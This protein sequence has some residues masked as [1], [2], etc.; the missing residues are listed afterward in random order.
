MIKNVIKFALGRIPY[1]QGFEQTYHCQ[2]CYKTLVLEGNLY[3]D[4]AGSEYCEECVVKHPS[5]FRLVEGVSVH[6]P[7][8][9]ETIH[10]SC[11]S[12]S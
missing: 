11:Q 8:M 12:V 7:M 10:D 1:K 5:Q 9:Y 4:D 3:I 2:Y 6:H